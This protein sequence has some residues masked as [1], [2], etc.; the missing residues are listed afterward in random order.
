[1]RKLLRAAFGAALAGWASSLCAESVIL[2]CE[3]FDDRGG[4]VVDSQFYD[5]M[6]SSY[7]L[8]HGLG[9]PV[10]DAQTA[11]DV[12]TAGT[13]RLFVRTMNWTACWT[14]RG[15]AGRFEVRV[16][17][18]AVP[19]EAPAGASF[20]CGEA[21]WRWQRGGTVT[22]SAGRHALA[23]HDLTG[24]DG[25]C[26]AVCLTTDDAPSPRA[27]VAAVQTDACDLLVVGGGVAG[28]SAAVSAARLG[29]RVA[30]VQ[31]RPV[32]GGNNSSEVRVHLGAYQNLPPYPRLGDVLAEYGPR[33]GG[34]ARPAANYEDERKMAV[35]RAE[36]NIALYLNTRAV[37][38]QASGTRNA[39][40]ID[41]VEA[42]DV[43]TGARHRFV[44]P[45]VADCTGDGTV[46][47]L[48]GADFRQGRE[49]RAEYGESLAPEK[50][51][52]M[53]MGASVQWYAEKG[54]APTAFP[55]EP[56]MIAFDEKSVRPGLRGDWDWET[57]LG[58]D[59]IG[60]AERIRDYGLLVV[61]SNWSYVKNAYSKRADF[62]AATLAWTAYVAGRRETRRLMG[63]FVLTERHLD[64]RAVQ[65]DGTCVT[66]WTI[67]QHYPWPASHT[68]Y[69]G[70]P[71]QAESRNKRIYPYPIPYRCLYSRNVDNLF[72][73]GRDISVSH[74][75][76][77]TT[78][79]MR[80]H[81]MMGEVVGMAASV[82][83]RRGCL[84]RAVYA[85]HFD[86]LRALMRRGVGTGAPQPP[87]DYNCQQSLDPEIKAKYRAARR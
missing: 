76:L 41:A 19:C 12:K 75:A 46:G 84:P 67:D 66:T 31:D 53:T 5:Q 57:G 45:L 73:A 39:R 13:Y 52:A 36:Q 27:P 15:A 3:R 51:D 30:L 9:Q 86:D 72:M 63:D 78:R 54:P 32:L 82:C 26:D 47:F 70:E 80:T 71:F 40:H 85:A 22:L 21:I 44:A 29:L 11:F 38:V 42:V 65:P 64:E 50:A 56:W 35:V 74:V 18:R 61:Y 4:W 16:D 69:A 33:A 37:A 17:A 83:R 62:A 2:E 81:G 49:A 1:M 28:I 55:Q 60:E 68:H 48:A 59:Q 23:L 34:N 24:F 25:R 7:L 79:L 14:D 10:A 8:A 58:R 6:G 20:G 43:V 77:G 87:Q